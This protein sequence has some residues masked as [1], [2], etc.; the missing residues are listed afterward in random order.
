MVKKLKPQKIFTIVKSRCPDSSEKRV[1]P[2]PPPKSP[3][4]LSRRTSTSSTCSSKPRRTVKPRR[5]LKH[6]RGPLFL[7]EEIRNDRLDA[8]HKKI[9]VYL[10]DFIHKMLT[11]DI[12]TDLRMDRLSQAFITNVSR[13][14][15][16]DLLLDRLLNV[17]KNDTTYA[18]NHHVID[19]MLTSSDVFAELMNKNL[20][21]VYYMYLEMQ[22][23][24][25]LAMVREK[26]GMH[27]GKRFEDVAPGFIEYLIKSSL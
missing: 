23:R 12:D 16:K 24:K 11:C 5:E 6:I 7:I 1:A 4:T 18:L 17:Y 21:E 14:H 3:N 10:F 25:D 27:I 2:T 20:M 22:Y 26:Y 9:K 13:K 8:I 15:L 19:T